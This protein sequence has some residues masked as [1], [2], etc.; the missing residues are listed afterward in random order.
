MARIDTNDRSRSLRLS[1]VSRISWLLKEEPMQN[2]VGIAVLISMLVVVALA[3]V[4]DG[5]ERVPVDQPST[6]AELP[7]A[8]AELDQVLADWEKAASEIHRLDCEFSRFKY[9]KTFAVEKR[10]EGT[11][12]IESAQR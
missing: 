5:D 12:A 6:P 8:A 3:D 7:K 1:S 10:G 11:I 9:D 4:A 2:H